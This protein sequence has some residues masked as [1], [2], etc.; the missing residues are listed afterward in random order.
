MSASNYDEGINGRIVI[1]CD[2]TGGFHTF[3]IENEE[4]FQMLGEKVK[5]KLQ[6]EKYT[7]DIYFF[8]REGTEKKNKND[9]VNIVNSK[10]DSEFDFRFII[11]VIQSVPICIEEN[12]VYN[13]EIVHKI[14]YHNM[15]IR[16]SGTVSMEMDMFY[17]SDKSFIYVI[18][19]STE[20]G[21]FYI[22]T[23]DE[24]KDTW[25]SSELPRNVFHV[26]QDGSYV[27]DQSLF[28]GY[29]CMNTTVHTVKFGYQTYLI[30]KNKND[31]N[32]VFTEEIIDSD[33]CFVTPY[34]PLK[35]D[36]YILFQNWSQTENCNKLHIVDAVSSSV[37]N[38]IKIGRE[39]H[40]LFVDN[41]HIGLY[42]IHEK[43]IHSKINFLTGEIVDNIGNK[44]VIGFFSYNKKDD[45]Y[46]YGRYNPLLKPQ[47]VSFAFSNVIFFERFV[48][49]RNYNCSK[50]DILRIK[51]D[52]EC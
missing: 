32:N 15:G 8:D 14:R 28:R 29:S 20:I 21:Y 17:V 51:H 43:N 48:V 38:I 33:R 19:P 37:I 31:D 50:I 9:V 7:H 44:K 45:T 1:L 5:E 13:L 11:D 47:T 6:L 52:R 10:V 49:V 41:E 3:N 26:Y 23:F 12:E 22:C 27:E 16:H 30:T 24:E 25:V 40:V 35:F 2:M 34:N 36:K 4:T 46:Q 42:Y 18:Y 39:E